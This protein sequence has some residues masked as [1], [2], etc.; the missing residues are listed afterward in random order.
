MQFETDGMEEYTRDADLEKNVGIWVTF[1]KRKLRVLR[2]GGSNTAYDRRLQQL[3]RPHTRTIRRQGELALDTEVLQGILRHAFAEKVVID[4]KGVNT[5][6][7]E[8]I[9]YSPEAC[10]A[11]FETWPEVFEEVKE[12][13][14]ARA[15]FQV[16]FLEGIKEDLGKN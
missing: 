9:P 4:W 12:I 10:M 5:P 1:G 6:N 7:G 15:S 3:M 14:S 2:A 16:E 8:A 13:A 11:F